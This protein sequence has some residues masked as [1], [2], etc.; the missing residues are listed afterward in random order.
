[1]N[2]I[3][4]GSAQIPYVQYDDKASQIIVQYST[5]RTEAVMN[6][7]KEELAGL[8]LSTNR[9]DWVVKLKHRT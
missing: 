2:M 4:I 7:K 8:L 1:M 3:P 5:G 6:V 9:Y